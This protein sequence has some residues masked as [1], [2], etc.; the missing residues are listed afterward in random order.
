MNE[1]EASDEE[2]GRRLLHEATFVMNLMWSSTG[3]TLTCECCSRDSDVACWP[4]ED[5]GRRLL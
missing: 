5:S 4:K 1:E 2:D 3:L